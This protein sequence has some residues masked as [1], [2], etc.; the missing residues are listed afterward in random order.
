MRAKDGL[1]TICIDTLFPTIAI[2]L[3]TAVLA[4]TVHGAGGSA[5]TYHRQTFQDLARPVARASALAQVLNHPWGCWAAFAC[6]RLW[7]GFVRVMIQSTR[8]AGMHA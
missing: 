6:A 3:H 2:A 8:V 5:S 4:A 1:L 7:P